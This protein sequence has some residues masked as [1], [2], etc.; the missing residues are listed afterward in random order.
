MVL[1]FNERL[2][3]ESVKLIFTEENCKEC[4]LCVENCP[5]KLLAVSDK[6]NSMG[7]HPV[8]LTNEEKCTQCSLCA[9]MCPD[10]VIRVS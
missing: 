2:W 7:F 6:T 9:I 3:G 4:L 1:S 8:Y 5:Q 10:T